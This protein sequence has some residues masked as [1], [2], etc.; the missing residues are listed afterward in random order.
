MNMQ[1]KLAMVV[2]TGAL[3]LGAGHVVQTRAD[4][5]LAA[6][7]GAPLLVSSVTLLAATDPVVQMPDLSEPAIV[8]QP[9]ASAVPVEPSAPDV[10]VA[11]EAATPALPLDCPLQL[12]A[13]PQ[14]GGLIGLT[15]LAPCHIGERVVLR[16][17]GLAVTARISESGTLFATLP[18]FK[19]EARVEV[20]FGSGEQTEVTV[21]VPEAEH[22][23]RF[24][25][26]WQDADAFQL[27]AFEGEA[28]YGA[29]G[30]YSAA[31]TGTIGQG[32]SVMLLGDNSTDL[33]LLAEVFTF[34]AGRD[35]EIVL[36]AAVTGATCGRELFAETLMAEGGRV[37]VADLT[38]AMPGCEAVGDIIVLK[39][40]AQD[41][42]LAAAQ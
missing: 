15:M 17:A 39:N 3:A 26:Q 8:V 35:A 7:E 34:A 5:R 1:R 29:P 30:H 38:L 12:D 27:H 21:S 37:D 25:V 24:A 31:F 18:A 4:N 28:S 16:H 42:K 20:R 13:I 40:L 6:T 11:A 10:I 19:A 36:E 2:A 22:L 32:A 9:S 23:R 14:S 41:M 33:P